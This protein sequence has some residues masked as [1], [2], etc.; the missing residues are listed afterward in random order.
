MGVCATKAQLDAIEVLSPLPRAADGKLAA[1][2]DQ[3]WADLRAMN[4]LIGMTNEQVRSTAVPNASRVGVAKLLCC[5]ALRRRCTRI[6]DISNADVQSLSRVTPP[7]RMF[8]CSTTTSMK[9]SPIV[10]AKTGRLPLTSSSRR[11]PR[12]C[13][14]QAKAGRTSRRCARYSRASTRMAR[15]T[16]PSRKCV[17]RCRAL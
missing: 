11:A 14:P 17:C 15:A 12:R 6:S 3:C 9:N 5:R 1:I 10:P 16:S 8:P 7:T 2:T 4:K 13:A